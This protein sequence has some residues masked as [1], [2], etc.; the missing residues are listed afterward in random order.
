MKVL[1][2]HQAFT[3]QNWGGVSKSFCELL[4]NKPNYLDYEIAVKESNN[5]HLKES[6]LLFDCDPISNTFQSFHRNHSIIGRE[7]L[8]RFLGRTGLLHTAEEVNKKLAIR[9]LKQ[10]DYDVFHATF[11][12][13]YFLPYLHGKPFVITIHDLMPELFGWRKEDPQIANKPL[14]CKKAAAI[15]AVSENTKADLCR[16]YDVPESKVHVVYHGGP[17]IL[18]DKPDDMVGAPYFLYVGRR[19]GYK[20]FEQ[21]LNDFAIFHRAYPKVLLVCTGG[22]FSKEERIKINQLGVSDVVVQH[23]ASD[24]DL[25][26]LYSNAIAF[27]FPS[28]YEGFGMPIL[29]AYACKCPV[30]LNKTSCFPEIAQDAAIFFDSSKDHSSLSDALFRIMEFSLKERNILIEKGLHRLSCFSWSQSANQLAEIYKTI[31]V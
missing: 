26:A 4:K 17:D 29:E 12:D 23:F 24:E 8:Y 16:F 1:Y 11:F 22:P 15:I 30:L 19:D 6:G 20:N 31:I 5:V 2:D 9:K 3:F 10:G 21:T 7:K 18:D 27:V 13:D 14:L 25:K 28:L